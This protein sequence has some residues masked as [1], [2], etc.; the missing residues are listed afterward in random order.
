MLELITLPYARPRWSGLLRQLFEDYQENAVPQEIPVPENGLADSI[1]QLG[2]ITIQG[3]HEGESL[4]L[5]VIEISARDTVEL[6]RNRVGIRNFAARLLAPG[7]ADGLLIA[8]I[9]PG[10]DSWRFTFVHRETRFTPDGDLERVETPTRRFTYVLGPDESCRTPDSRFQLLARHRGSTTLAHVLD[11]FSVEKLSDEFFTTYKRHYADF[12]HHLIENSALAQVLGIDLTGLEGKERDRALKP[13]RDFVKKLLGRLVF[14]HFIQKKGWLGCPPLSGTDAALPQESMPWTGGSS[15]F[16]REM[17]QSALPAEQENFHS[18]RLVPLFFQTLNAPDRAGLVF[19]I[20]GNRVPYLNGGLFEPDFP[21]VEAVDFPAPLFAALLEFFRQYHFTIDENDPEDHEIGIDPEMLGRIFE[22]LLED[23][24]DKGAYYTPKPVVQYMCQQSL[25]HALTGRY[26]SDAD[27]AA[28]IERLVRL[29]EPVNALANSWLARHATELSAHLNDLRICDPA[30]G[31]GAFPIGLLQE[32][33]W[34]KLTLNPSLDR[35]HAKRGIIQHCIHGVDL[36]AGAVEIARL[37]F[38]LA[39]IVEEN[40][41]TPLPNLDYQI[42]QGNSLLESFRGERLDDLDQPIRYGVRVLG[43][44]QHELDL[45][46]GGQIELTVEEDTTAPARRNLAAL[47]ESYYACHEPAE[48]ARLRHEIDAAVLRAID[49]RLARRREELEN[50]LAIRRAE[51]LKKR[52]ANPRYTT[53]AAAQRKIDKNQAELDALGITT[54]DLHALLEDPRKERPFFLWHLWFRQILAEAPEGRGGFDIVIA[55][56]P[57]VRHEAIKDQK[58]ALK[59]EGYECYSGTADL[60]VY[61]YEQALRKL[62]PGGVLCFI[63]SNSLLNSDFGLPLRNY[64]LE[65]TRILTLLDFAEAPVFNAVTEPVIVAAIRGTRSEDD[66]VTVLK[67]N[68]NWPIENVSGQVAVHGIEMPQTS[69]S[70]E[71]WRLESREV[72]ALLAKL[73]SAGEALG[74]LVGDRFYYGIKTG[75]NEAYIISHA[76]RRLLI[77][78]HASSEQLIQPFL[79]GKDIKKWEPEYSQQHLIRI[80]SS[81]NVRHSWSGLPLVEAEQAFSTEFPAIHRWLNGFRP[82]LMARDDHGTYFWELRSCAYWAEFAAPKIVYQEINRTDVFAFDDQG[83]LANNKIFILPGASKYML[84]LMNSRVGIWFIHAFSGV[85][86]GGFLALQTPIMS[87]FPIPAATPTEQAT[88]TTLVDSILA[89]KR[90]G[91][92]ATVKELEAQI[93]RHVFRL[94]G[95]TPEE[96][97]LVRGAS[98]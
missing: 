48:K 45:G 94:Y 62:T 77:E 52:R 83:Y 37:R 17:F 35:A 86:F 74:D 54:A 78:E 15:D 71:V 51:E 73:R 70:P 67:W 82:K 21:G 19:P 16:L 87:A 2:V 34:T 39:L 79:R 75:C 49:A 30:I 5:A 60:Y 7:T 8:T 92:E 29:K 3:N 46:T 69:L 65:R 38:W 6:L 85:P 59:A 31:S 13:L 56:P 84:A 23:N 97:A 53:P 11:A 50:S 12:C 25:I 24:K 32:I 58:P 4:S 14:L 27:A 36:D 18:S 26:A 61:F 20:T 44:D 76:D 81:A 91:D 90:M 89:A 63:T 95:L 98:A 43:K 42:M 93:D 33:Y 41:P 55:N 28:E 96:I 72:L 10:N 80:E 22:N 88:L 40:V 68:E 9:Q 57:Y 64:F 66:R 1:H 47:R